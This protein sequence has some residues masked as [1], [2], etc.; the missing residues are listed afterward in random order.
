MKLH[1]RLA[2]AF[3][4]DLEKDNKQVLLETHLRKQFELSGVDLVLDVGANAGQ[5]GKLLRDDLG[6]AGE[7]HS[8]EPQPDAFARLKAAA[9]RDPHWRVFNLA[10][11]DEPGKLAMNVSGDDVFSSFHQSSAKGRERFA[12]AIQ[13]DRTIDV[14]IDTLANHIAE[15]ITDFDQRRVFLKMDTQGHDG[16]VFKG[17]GPWRNRFAGLVSELSVVGI[18][19]GVPDYL[20]ALA[21]YREYN[22]EM[23]GA[24]VVNRHRQTGHIVDF[25]CVLAPLS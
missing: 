9:I 5:F 8:F 6:Y 25:D 14:P 21:L 12:R 18:Y 1:R 22:Y 23:T 2:R 4:Y 20:E 3:G 11:G 15:H 24:F 19:D 13:Q 17:A 7:I 16:W 10:L